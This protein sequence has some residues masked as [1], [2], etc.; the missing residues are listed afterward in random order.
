MKRDDTTDPERRKRGDEGEASPAVEISAGDVSPEIMIFQYL[1]FLT[2][3]RI[4]H[5]LNIFKIK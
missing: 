2:P 4:L 3:G 1:F 5:F